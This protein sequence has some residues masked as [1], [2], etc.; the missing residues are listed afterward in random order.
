MLYLGACALI[1]PRVE[2]EP[3]VPRVE[4]D[5]EFAAARKRAFE[6]RGQL[7]SKIADHERFEFWTGVGLFG[8]GIA[9]LAVGIY[10]GSKDL[11]LGI[12]LGGATVAGA[13]LFIPSQERRTIY[14]DGELAVTCA[15]TALSIE[16]DAPTEADLTR[17]R[18]AGAD[19]TLAGVNISGL[20]RQVEQ[21]E[22][23]LIPSRRL[24]DRAAVPLQATRLRTD[25]LQEDLVAL[26]QAVASLER[27]KA[28]R[29]D[30]AL[31][32]ISDAVNAQIGQQAVNPT[33]ARSAAF[34]EYATLI[35]NIA[36]TL[37][38]V[39]AS[40]ERLETAANTTEAAATGIDSAAAGAGAQ[41]RALARD[42]SSQME[43]I[44]KRIGLPAGCLSA[45][46]TG[47]Q[48]GAS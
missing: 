15:L 36:S 24:A 18:G 6:L 47:A 43:I 3:S 1:E 44:R 23:Q 21:Q 10:D 32:A 31:L 4:E 11:L 30:A 40:A 7:S 29:L 20:R 12:G 8:L 28:A 42:I 14:S 26:E 22:R 16:S 35:D 17:A 33:A 39:E 37:T 2:F 25:Q 27:L 13:R 9:G 38:A 46:L 5:E 34:S 19:T 45:G 41:T 48:P